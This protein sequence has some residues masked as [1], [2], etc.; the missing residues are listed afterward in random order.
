LE[1]VS[2]STC[3]RADLSNNLSVVGAVHLQTCQSVR[4]AVNSASPLVDGAPG[5]SNP[6]ALVSVLA[7]VV[8]EK[9]QGIKSSSAPM[10]V[11][12]SGF[13]AAVPALIDVSSKWGPEGSHV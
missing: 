1:V 12:P 13:P 4:G 2:V 6:A 7:T 5:S 11:L 9:S 8:I 10:A 3:S